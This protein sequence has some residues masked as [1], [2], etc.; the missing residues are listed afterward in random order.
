VKTRKHVHATVVH[1]SVV[2]YG[3]RETSLLM[4]DSSVNF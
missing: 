3:H 1:F 2:T 4:Q